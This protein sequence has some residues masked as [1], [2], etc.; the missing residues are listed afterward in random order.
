MS[1]ASRPLSS[2]QPALITGQPINCPWNDLLRNRIVGMPFLGIWVVQAQD[3]LMRIEA[4]PVVMWHWFI[5]LL[6]TSPQQRLNDNHLWI[7]HEHPAPSYFSHPQGN[8]HSV[9]LSQGL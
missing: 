2:C 6:S 7:G 3:G 1:S 9:P 4:V 8:P 5:R